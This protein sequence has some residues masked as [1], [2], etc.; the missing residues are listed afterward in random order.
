M[1]KRKGEKPRR[2]PTR[3]QLSQ[4]Q[5]QKRRQRIILGAGIFIV[6]AIVGIVG[7]GI[8]SQW[9]IAEYK[10]RQQ[11]VVSVNGTEFDMDYYIKMLN[12]YGEGQPATF[13]YQLVNEAGTII[14][15]NELIRQEAL[16]LGFS[17][18][19]KEVDE[20]LKNHDPPFTDVHR[21]T[22]RI[23][24]LLRKLQDE[25]FEPSNYR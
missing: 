21:D 24:L 22:I 16:A 10:P 7:V 19:D 6:V 9:Y 4:W 18:S 14:E 17:V 15:R 1:V 13:I 2:E 12:F 5:K 8:Y 25:Y 11:T 3:R 20:E 23:Q